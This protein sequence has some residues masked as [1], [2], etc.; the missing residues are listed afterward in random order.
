MGKLRLR[1]WG[2]DGQGDGVREWPPPQL[3]MST[4]FLN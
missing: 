1:E 2:D 3:D 4:W